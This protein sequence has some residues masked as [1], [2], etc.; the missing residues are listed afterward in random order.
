MKRKLI[1]FSALVAV[2][3]FAW[4]LGR[5]HADRFRLNNPQAIKSPIADAIEIIE[6]EMICDDSQPDIVTVYYRW[7]DADGNIISDPQR[8]I[9]TENC[10]AW[11]GLRNSLWNK[12]KNDIL[13]PGNDGSF[14]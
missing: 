9:C 5:S 4:W 8:W 14:E 3:M 1:I 13:L 6:I 2:I 7:I 12:M 10:G 11:N